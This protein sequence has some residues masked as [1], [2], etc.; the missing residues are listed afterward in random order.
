MWRDVML[1]SDANRF[2]LLAG[3]VCCSAAVDLCH[4]QMSVAVRDAQSNGPMDASVVAEHGADQFQFEQKQQGSYASTGVLKAH[5]NNLRF[6][7]VPNATYASRRIELHAT[8]AQKKNYQ[9]HLGKKLPTYT[10]GYLERCRNLLAQ[11]DFD[12]ALAA[13]EVAYVASGLGRSKTQFDVKLKFNFARGLANACQILGYNTCELARNLYAELK[14]E[15][16]GNQR[17]FLAE[18]IT[19]QSLEQT[20]RELDVTKVSR[21]YAVFKNVFGQGDYEQ[22][23]LLAEGMLSQFDSNVAVF[24]AAQLTKD[25]L[26]EDVGTAYA[27][28][29]LL[30]DRDGT[31]TSATVIAQKALGHF[32]D[33]SGK[34]AVVARNISDLEKRM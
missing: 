5:P 29:A 27:R 10:F 7:L 6:N 20:L 16:S 8:A 24:S 19:V 34:S 26:R 4:A 25:R 30:T 3:L 22:A 18:G 23:A 31:K 13:L 11:G 15:I 21:Q 12:R 17:L 32:R 9:F 33:I 2:L 28:A 1:R 14:D